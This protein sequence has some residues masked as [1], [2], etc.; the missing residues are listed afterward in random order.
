MCGSRLVNPADAPPAES[1]HQDRLG[2]AGGKRSRLEKTVAEHIHGYTY[3]ASGLARSPVSLDELESLKVSVGFTVEDE[4]ALR[5]AG[6]VLT[7]QTEQIVDLWRSG[8]IAAIPNLARH[9]RSPEGNP[10]PAYSVNSGLRLQQWILDTCLRPYDQDWLDYQHEIALRHTSVKKNRT[11]D[12]QS[13]PYIPLRDILAFI[14]V[15]NETIKPF[16]AAK[17]DSAETVS[18]MHEAWC[19]S[20]QLQMALWAKPYMDDAANEW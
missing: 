9:S 8:I 3:G 10:L 14:A 4:R 16:L 20:M 7:K 6:E 1:L 17:R 2:A 19:K 11:D 18:K 15:M 5:L 13:T 12:V